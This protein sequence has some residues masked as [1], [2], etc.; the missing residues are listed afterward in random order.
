MRSVPIHSSVDR[1]WR[2]AARARVMGWNLSEMDFHGG[3]RLSEF[4]Y[5]CD[6]SDGEI[7]SGTN[8]AEFYVDVYL[9]FIFNH[10]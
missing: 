4:L 6:R 1:L 10:Q 5:R 7:L 8:E 3:G 9:W 2:T